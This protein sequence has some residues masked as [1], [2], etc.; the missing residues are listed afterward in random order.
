M[1]QLKVRLKNCYGICDLEHSF[2]FDNPTDQGP[3]KRSFAIYAPNGTMKSSFANT[4]LALASGG[5]PKEERYN[6]PTECSV[7]EDG[8]DLNPE[9]IYVLKSEVDISSNSKAITDILVDP[10]SK[11]R[12]DDLIL[13]TEMSKSA[14]IV[15]IQKSSK[16]KKADIESTLI[17]DFDALS[18]AD[19]IRSATATETPEDLSIYEYTTIFDPKAVEV[20]RS[21]NFQER[22]K[23][24]SARYQK[25]FEES[26]GI[27]KKGIF[28]P[29]KADATLSSLTRNGFFK[30][31]HRVHLEGENASITE[32]ELSVKLKE[33]NSRIDNDVELKTLHSSLAKNAQTQALAELL[34]T[35]TAAETEYLLEKLTPGNEK[36]FRKEIWVHHIKR[37]PEATTYLS[38]HDESA[39]EI[40][41]IEEKSKEITPRWERAV[42]RFNNRFLDMPFTLSI[43]NKTKTFV[44]R[45]LAKLSFEFKNG[46]DSAKCD[47]HG[48]K[49][50]SQGEKRALYLLNFIFEVEARILANQKTLFIIDDAADSFDYKNKHAIV[51]YLE[52][53]DRNTLFRQI[54]LTH[55]F[56][57]FRTLSTTFVHRD[58]CLMANRHGDSL[59]LVKAEGVSNIFTK[60]WKKEIPN[61]EAVICASISFTRN[62]IEYT[63]GTN[64]EN[65]LKLTSLL[66]WKEDTKGISIGDYIKIYNATF[67]STHP[68]ND[69][70]SICDLLFKVAA[71]LCEQGTNEAL[72]LEHKVL[73]SIAIRIKAEAVMTELLRT[74]KNDNTYWCT[75]SSQFGAMLG[76]LKKVTPIEPALSV[77][78]RVS[79]VTS[80][81]IHLNSFMYEPI[82]DLSN[83]HLI[84]LL[85][86][87]DDLFN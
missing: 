4:F 11:Q 68:V 54:L 81:N 55:N 32:E 19:A 75:S 43:T 62:I 9:S 58:R 22:A 84:N 86:D 69:D 48:M 21:G 61:N 50:L 67:N 13:S 35:L 83:D 40:N 37:L 71:E 39:D 76:E 2:E 64:D 79:I 27:Y 87:V 56:D 20:L 73:M 6:R 1:K 78:D 85:R 26:N 34:E 60:K 80:S 66:H 15:A 8:H 47:E 17:S 5:A 70:S 49:N 45:E 46:Q 25:I 36:I 42:E 28:N 10:E 7:L 31:G 29:T 18:L 38:S 59:R 63:R 74:Y 14:L 23:E 3:K 77:L 44:G 16:V 82:L 51:Q 72:N 57:F 33:I 53:I 30:V 24:F 12:Y 65:Y 52:D 41:Q